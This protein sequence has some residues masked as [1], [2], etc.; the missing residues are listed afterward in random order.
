MK[1]KKA[2]L[3]VFANL[4]LI[5]PT[6]RISLCTQELYTLD[7]YIIQPQGLMSC[8]FRNFDTNGD[9][10]PCRM[11]WPDGPWDKNSETHVSCSSS[12]LRIAS[13]RP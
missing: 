3:L 5:R 12:S 4:F 13:A 11:Q 7:V 2:Y 9:N 1:D 6:R 8:Y 10:S